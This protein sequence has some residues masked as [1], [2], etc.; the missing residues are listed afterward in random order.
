[1]KYH[2]MHPR[3]AFNKLNYYIELASR[4]EEIYIKGVYQLLY[5]SIRPGTTVLDIGAAIGDTAIYFAMNPNA[6][7]VISYEPF[8]RAFSLLLQN[9]RKYPKIECKQLAIGKH[10][11]KHIKD[12]K[13]YGINYDS[14]E[15]STG[16][17]IESIT[18]AEA[19]K[20]LTNVVIKSDCEGAEGYMFND[21]DLSEVYAIQ[22]EYHNNRGDTVSS[23]EKKGFKIIQEDNPLPDIYGRCPKGF[24]TIFA[25]KM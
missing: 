14:E 9:T 19:L 2:L 24:G 5:D 15:G 21:A 12:K 18:L 13:S 22:L 16:E 11:I 8:P 7:K 4:F 25:K 6:K 17:K 23:L 10:Q 1:M 20:G 3:K